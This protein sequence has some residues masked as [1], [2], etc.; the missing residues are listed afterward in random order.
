MFNDLYPIVTSLLTLPHINTVNDEVELTR[1]YWRTVFLDIQCCYMNI[2]NS[3]SQN[4]CK[5]GELSP[6]FERHMRRKLQ[7]STEK[8]IRKKEERKE[9]GQLQPL[10]LSGHAV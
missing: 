10:L 7:R 9:I 1:I 8:Q 6:I 3:V 4:L 2:T 5:T